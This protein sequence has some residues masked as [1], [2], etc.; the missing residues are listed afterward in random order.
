MKN[1]MISYVVLGVVTVLACIEHMI[2]NLYPVS[3]ASMATDTVFAYL[4]GAALLG[5]IIAHCI[6]SY[7]E[8]KQKRESN[9]IIKK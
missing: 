6:D 3:P 5:A 2:F 9:K 4:T 1:T 7:I 8:L